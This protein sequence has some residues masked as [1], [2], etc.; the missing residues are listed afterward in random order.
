MLGGQVGEL[1][2]LVSVLDDKRHVGLTVQHA[3][4][5]GGHLSAGDQPV[6]TE[7]AVAV[8]L[9]PPVLD[10]VDHVAV[11]PIVGVHIGEDV[12]AAG[13]H[14]GKA[15]GHGGE[16]SA[17]DLP[18]GLELVVANAVYN[19][20]LR[21][22]VDGSGVPGAVGHVVEGGLSV[23][24]LVLQEVVEHLGGLGAGHV[25]IGPEAVVG[26]AEQVLNVV[27][28]L[29]QVGHAGL[30]RIGGV[31]GVLLNH[32]RA[33]GSGNSFHV[34]GYFNLN[35]HFVCGKFPSS[36][37]IIYTRRIPSQCKRGEFFLTLGQLVGVF[38]S[39]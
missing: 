25:A 35:G 23:H 31:F 2:E 11:E 18:V 26:I 19:A 10:G 8:T 39:N 34:A 6:G 12:D 3:V 20:Q 5:D 33:A 16:L 1:G 14:L 7:G 22:D 29:Q 13:G 36:I 9:D 28:G 15:H 4:D 21:H 27:V 30:V 37:L 24:I 17:G 38:H 32:D